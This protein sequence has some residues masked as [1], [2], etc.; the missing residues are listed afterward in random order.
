[1]KCAKT[2]FAAT[3]WRQRPMIS[4]VETG[5]KI[6]I[7]EWFLT[8]YCGDDGKTQMRPDGESLY[9]QVY[10]SRKRLKRAEI[11]VLR[12]GRINNI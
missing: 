9:F 5:P 2:A 1:M 11:G 6:L 8:E 10:W 7:L 4:S 3:A 12:R